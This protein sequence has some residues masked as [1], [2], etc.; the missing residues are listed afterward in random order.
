MPPWEEVWRFFLQELEARGLVIGAIEKR[1]VVLRFLKAKEQFDMA[2][3]LADRTSK[4]HCCE[5]MAYLT[6][7]LVLAFG[8]EGA[9]LAC[10]LSRRVLS[11][12]R[13]PLDPQPEIDGDADWR[14]FARAQEQQVSELKDEFMD[15][16]N[17]ALVSPA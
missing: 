1:I 6:I 10:A 11:G 16:A 12:A 8:Y 17:S 14:L 5:G 9:S 3:A 2:Y 4:S 13:G 7:G 15:I